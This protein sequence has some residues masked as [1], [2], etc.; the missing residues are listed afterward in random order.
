MKD[1]DSVEVL[2]AQIAT[3]I[4]HISKALDNHLTE[5]GAW[6]IKVDKHIGDYEMK[7]AQVRGA[8]GTMCLIAVFIGT[9]FTAFLDKI[10]IAMFG[11]Q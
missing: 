3:D 11:A 2:V 5:F 7:K 8:W 4:K 10:K 1:K 6:K 9:I